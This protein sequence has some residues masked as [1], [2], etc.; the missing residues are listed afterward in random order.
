MKLDRVKIINGLSILALVAAV[1]AAGY[2][3]WQYR[4]ASDK[5]EAAKR[6]VA[7]TVKSVSALMLVPDEVPT[8]ATVSDK[9]KLSDQDF[10][11][12]AENGDKVLIYTQAKKAIL[13]RPSAN[14]IVDVAPIRTVDQNQSAS[15]AQAALKG[16]VAGAQASPTQ[17]VVATATPQPISVA[18]Y[19][20][21]ETQG[22]SYK[23]E[24]LLKTKFPIAVN[25]RTEASKKDYAKTIVVDVSDNASNRAQEIAQ[26]LKAD[27]S[28]LPDGEVKPESDILVIIGADR[29]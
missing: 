7:A 27:V 6:E 15:E 22:L 13:Y 12:N 20:G 26:F 2:F 8:L 14:K 1:S 24:S 4:A 10:F 3:Y 29:K 19:N 9:S 23:L 21:T 5:A 11:R 25:S 17:A 28:S 18:M 16:Q